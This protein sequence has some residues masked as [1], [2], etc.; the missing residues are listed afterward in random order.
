MSSV[1]LGEESTNSATTITVSKPFATLIIARNNIL[2][3][4]NN[5]TVL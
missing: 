4:K 1:K 3:L 2:S 5:L